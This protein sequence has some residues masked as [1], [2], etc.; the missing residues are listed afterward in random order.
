MQQGGCRPG[1]LMKCARG[2]R[3]RDKSARPR[4]ES[5]GIRCAAAMH[6]QSTSPEA[7]ATCLGEGE[8]GT[9]N[10]PLPCPDCFGEG[11]RL[12]LAERGEGRMRDIARAPRGDAHR[13]A[14]GM[15]WLVFG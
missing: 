9:E 3:S 8:I 5:G 13:C 1:Q 6:E 10:G 11:R 4:P 7:C 12:A 14:P 2:L 15:N